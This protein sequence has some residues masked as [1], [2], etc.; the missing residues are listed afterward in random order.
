MWL[1]D[2]SASVLF[3]TQRNQKLEIPEPSVAEEDSPW[4]YWFATN[5]ESHPIHYGFFA[6]ESDPEFGPKKMI[7]TE[8]EF[9][10]ASH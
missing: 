2:L 4:R 3:E 7:S 5:K 8:L 9:K 6:V 10:G 1:S